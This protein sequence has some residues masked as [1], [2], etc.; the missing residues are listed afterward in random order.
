M[1]IHIGSLTK[2][3]VLPICFANVTACCGCHSNRACEELHATLDTRT[4]CLHH[5]FSTHPSNNWIINEALAAWIV[6]YVQTP[7]AIF[8]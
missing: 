7:P 5:R 2:K 4:P 8:C 6:L 3:S 1:C